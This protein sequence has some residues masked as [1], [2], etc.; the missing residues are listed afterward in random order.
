MSQKQLNNITEY[1]KSFKFNTYDTKKYLKVKG[2]LENFKKFYVG[3]NDAENA[4]FIWCLEAVAFIQKHYIKVFKLL[5][6]EQFQKAWDCLFDI[7][8]AIKA[9]KP[10]FYKYFNEYYLDV[11]EDKV[12]KYQSLYPYKMFMSIGIIVEEQ[13]CSICGQVRTLRTPCEHK[14][15]EIYNGEYCNRITTKIKKFDHVSFVKN[16]KDKRCILTELDGKPIDYDYSLIK[17]LLRFVDKPLEHWD[18][19]WSKIRHPHEL[20]KNIK[21]NDECPCGS[22]K[23]YQDCCL[24]NNDGVLRPHCDFISPKLRNKAGE[25]TY[26]Y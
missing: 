9:L 7:E 15:G 5:K 12:K 16:P 11:I 25:I 23:T 1:L 6:K 19:K 10:H 8:T 13:K 2:Q 3:A 26:H 17:E 21:P 22:E 24:N 14:V 20:F 4:K 18:I